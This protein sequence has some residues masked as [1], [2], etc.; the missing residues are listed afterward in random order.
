M[1]R[2]SCLHGSPAPNSPHCFQRVLPDMASQSSAEFWP[3]VLAM[4]TAVRHNLILFS[5]YLLCVSLSTCD[6]R[7][8]H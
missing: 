7:K 4:S 6:G 3:L 2:W 5:E 8:K 1:S